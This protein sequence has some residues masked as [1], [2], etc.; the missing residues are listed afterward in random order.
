MFL[1]PPRI[2][3]L[4]ITTNIVRVIDKGEGRHIAEANSPI[5]IDLN[6]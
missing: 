4:T 2:C 1:L 6:E 5:L 3:S